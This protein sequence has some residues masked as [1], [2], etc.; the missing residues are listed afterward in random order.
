MNLCVPSRLCGE[1]KREVNR[2]GAKSA[3]RAVQGFN[4]RIRSGNSLSARSSQG[5][6]VRLRASNAL[7]KIDP[8]A[9]PR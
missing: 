1:R 3:E 7:Y 5:E 9:L 4:A 6:G 2:R 8:A